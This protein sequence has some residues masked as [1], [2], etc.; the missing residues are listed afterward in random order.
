MS[1][2]E[3]NVE[4][5]KSLV[6]HTLETNGV[7]GEI[8]AQ[9]RANVYKAIDSEEDQNATSGSRPAAKLM[10]SPVGR[11]MAEIVAEFFE[12]YEFKH[13]LSV[14]VPESNLGK[15]R[16]SRTEVAF[17][18]GLVR[19]L[20]DVSILEQLVGLATG[21]DLRKGG[22]EDWHS[23]ASSTTA[24]SPPPTA[25]VAATR[26]S[27]SEGFAAKAECETPP[28]A[29][30]SAA[31]ME[32]D[33]GG[34]GANA[35]SEER[36][37]SRKGRHDKQEAS[38]SQP[39]ESSLDEVGNS[40]ERRKPLG[41]LPSLAGPGKDR[42]PLA[43][44]KVPNSGIGGNS[45]GLEEVSL[46]EST[47]GVS[48]ES[49]E[50]VR[51][52]MLRLQ[53]I[54]RK[55]ARLNRSAAAASSHRSDVNS[56]SGSNGGSAREGGPAPELS[57]EIEASSPTGPP[58]ARSLLRSASASPANSVIESPARSP[59]LSPAASPVASPAASSASVA[60]SQGAQSEVQEAMTPHS[61]GSGVL[62]G[63]QSPLSA[64][65]GGRGS[66]PSSF[67]EENMQDNVQE[68]SISID[69][70]AGS[71]SIDLTGRPSGGSG[72]LGGGMSTVLRRAPAP[73]AAPSQTVGLADEVD[74]ESIEENV[75]GG[76]FEGYETSEAN[77]SNLSSS[78]RL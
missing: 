43:H 1:S 67:L 53:Q 68:E 42:D 28:L 33:A 58:H 72:G 61:E 3:R 40:R 26:P 18:A 21:S 65:G 70:S 36:E 4:E 15:E 20:S 71:G 56:N 35:A 55:I 38:H 60:Q 64:A 66:N 23:S 51:E 25:S 48:R 49:F 5:L 75:S 29:S 59:A 22:G 2:S 57:P 52:D 69:E 46:G 10:T 76:S 44:L 62:P 8:R 54:D 63:G 9:L 7:L 73:L 78:E 45:S 16:R 37:D 31:S 19:V 27:I 11:L 13:S 50:E 47:G 17:D 41:K 14:L 30:S 34:A 32:G 6:V 39:E 77:L 24:S 12:F 74:E